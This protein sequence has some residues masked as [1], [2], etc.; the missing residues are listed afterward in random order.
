MY[1]FLDDSRERALLEERRE[2]L[3]GDCTPEERAI[4]EN[5]AVRAKALI[6]K[7]ASMKE[8]FIQKLREISDR[9]T[10][11]LAELEAPETLEE[12]AEALSETDAPPDEGT[13][14]APDTADVESEETAQAVFD[15]GE[16]TGE[17]TAQAIFDAGETTG[18]ETAQAVFGDM[19]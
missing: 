3:K 13:P 15:A 14:P 12:I 11:A 10:A 8:E 16:T 9:A 2:R 6:A 19:E 4:L 17:E 1:P 5:S 7:K 18:E